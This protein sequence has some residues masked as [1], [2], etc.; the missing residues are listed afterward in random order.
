MQMQGS[1]NLSSKMNCTRCVTLLGVKNS[2][3]VLKCGLGRLRDGASDALTRVSILVGIG[4]VVLVVL[5]EI[6]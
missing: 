6:L 1:R 3:A 2:L 4:L 5:P